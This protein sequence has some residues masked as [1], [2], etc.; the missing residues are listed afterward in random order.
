MAKGKKG[1]SKKSASNPS[2][3]DHDENSRLYFTSLIADTEDMLKRS[4]EECKTLT[5]E[6]NQHKL[7]HEKCQ[8]DKTDMSNYYHL[9]SLNSSEKIRELKVELLDLEREF[10]E[11]SLEASLDFKK[12]EER[13][14]FEMSSLENENSMLSNQVSSLSDYS[15]KRNDLEKK[16]KDLEEELVKVKGEHAA[17]LYVL[18]KEQVK[19]KDRQK[20]EMQSRVN[21]V[22]SE[23]RRVSNQQMAETTKRTISVNLVVNSKLIKLTERVRII[24][25]ENESLRKNLIEKSRKLEI[26]E[27]N[28]QSLG[29]KNK[30]SN[31]LISLLTDK[32]HE[33]ETDLCVT[34][35]VLDETVEKLEEYEEAEEERSIKRNM[36][37]KLRSVNENLTQKRESLC[38]DVKKMSSQVQNLRNLI[39]KCCLI[40][41][42][43][44]LGII[45]SEKNTLPHLLTL[46]YSTCS[47]E[48]KKKIEQEVKSSSREKILSFEDGEVLFVPKDGMFVNYVRGV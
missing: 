11:V 25:N 35:E 5:E 41:A 9:M 40:F 4:K 19:D 30:C 33:I 32:S 18:E 46:L 42:H 10:E 7:E 1:K 6:N 44:K 8:Q 24:M 23:F 12:L 39:D 45:N 16:Y 14:Q 38:N 48:V 28:E 2:D 31:R 21:D 34:E 36:S 27:K 13:I 47:P 20:K 37:D 15:D 17:E 3:T 22:A 43:Q 29:K 26:L